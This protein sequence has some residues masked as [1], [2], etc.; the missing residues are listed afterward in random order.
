[1]FVDLSS[2]LLNPTLAGPFDLP[3][4][5]LHNVARPVVNLSFAVDRAIWGLSS[6]GFHVTNAV[7]HIMVVGLFYGWCTRALSFR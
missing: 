3:A 2:V 7:L 4:V 5:L 6:F 1:M